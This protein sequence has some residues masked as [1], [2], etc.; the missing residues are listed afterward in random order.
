MNSLQKQLTPRDPQYLAW[1]NTLP[2][3]VC[4]RTGPNEAH[5]AK[6]GGLGVKSSDYT[7]IPLCNEHHREW[8]DKYGKKG[9]FGEEYIDMLI[10]QLQEVYNTQIKGE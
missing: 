10:E 7:A 4:F 3:A 5:H 9:P 8:H 1:I 6:S 2:C